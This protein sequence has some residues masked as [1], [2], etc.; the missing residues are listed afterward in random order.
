MNRLSNAR[1]VNVIAAEV[2]FDK[3]ESEAAFTCAASFP[4]MGS[5]HRLT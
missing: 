5:R 3:E 2:R 1:D 4:R